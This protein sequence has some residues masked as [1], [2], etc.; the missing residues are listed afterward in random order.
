MTVLRGFPHLDAMGIY[1]TLE[2]LLGQLLLVALFVAALAKTFWPKRSVT[3]TTMPTAPV[4]AAPTTTPVAS[5]SMPNRAADVG[6]ERAVPIAA[7][8][9]SVQRLEERVAE[10]EKS[11]QRQASARA[12]AP[13]AEEE[14]FPGR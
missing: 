2:T 13:F 4:P 14:S 11:V 10:L 5:R 9:E 12:D 8:E 3:L 7:L 1:P 6:E